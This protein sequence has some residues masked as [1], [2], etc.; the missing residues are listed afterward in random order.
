MSDITF[1]IDED[2]Q[3]EEITQMKINMAGEKGVSDA[4][5]SEKTPHLMVVHY[6]HNST[7]SQHLLKSVC[8]QGYHAE[9]I[10]F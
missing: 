2:L 6:D 4:H 5:L 8:N 1:H 3:T 10:G 7:N 9:L